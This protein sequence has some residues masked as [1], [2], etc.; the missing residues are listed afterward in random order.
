MVELC[1]NIYTIQKIHNTQMYITK[2]YVDT[3]MVQISVA[4][5]ANNG[6]YGH[7]R[8]LKKINRM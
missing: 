4:P 6:M 1:K 3:L 2:G 8:G 7:D 5:F